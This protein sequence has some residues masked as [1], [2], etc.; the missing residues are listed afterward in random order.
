MN[1]WKPAELALTGAARLLWP[2]FQAINRRFEGKPFH[3]AWA[4]APMLKSRLP[5]RER[6]SLSLLVSNPV[7]T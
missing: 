3:P 4:P 1:G 5:D 2:A 6:S 7:A